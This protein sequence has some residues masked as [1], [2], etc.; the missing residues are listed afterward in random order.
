V[1][2]VLGVGSVW[3]AHADVI[4]FIP[5]GS[6][7]AF[8]VA[9]F[10]EKV[11]NALSV[12]AVAAIGATPIGGTS[13]PFTTL[14]QAVISSL[15]NSQ[16]QQIAA[17]GLGGINQLTIVAS[18]NETATVVNPNTVNLNTNIS[19]AG[20][21][22]E[23]YSNPA[24]N[25]NDLAGTGFRDGTLILKGVA[26]PGPVNAGSFSTTPNVTQQFD[27]FPS[28][29]SNNYPGVNSVVGQGAT[30]LTFQVTSFNPNFFA[31]P[32][33]SFS[34]NTSNVVPFSQTDP[35]KLVYNNGADTGGAL[36]STNR[37]V[38]PAG[39]ATPNYAPNIG[40]ING[41]TG[42]DF[43]FQT[44]ANSSFTAAAV[45]EPN[46]IVMSLSGVGFAC[47]A[48]LRQM[49]NRRKLSAA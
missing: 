40:T 27:Q 10:D 38:S 14:Y 21:Y 25:A 33:T 44:D 15:L 13:A 31:T 41:L 12:N 19:Q 39:L 1:V 42:T 5:N 7:S 26:N 32:I 45:P 18:F 48:G 11:G 37:G 34:F 8:Q 22:V 16:G 9:T 29:A 23:I 24:N 2:T 28:P 46:I 35:S 3:P 6:G 47:V 20:S 30:T 36:N 43:Q 17:P 49:R 4:N